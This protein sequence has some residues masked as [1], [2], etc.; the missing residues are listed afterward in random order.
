M[1]MITEGDFM[2]RTSFPEIYT[3]FVDSEDKL[4][5]KKH[6][7]FS[8]GLVYGVL[9]QG[10][11]MESRPDMVDI[12]RLNQIKEEVTKSIIDF[13]FMLLHD[14]KDSEYK[15]FNKMLNIADEGVL[16]LKTIYDEHKYLPLHD[17]IQ[18]SE[19]LWKERYN[20]Y[21]ILNSVSE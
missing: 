13:I 11:M 1:V 15:T 12:V 2:I 3:E 19:K 9:H 8:L 18:E 6:H 16:K 4:F 17:L 14:N 21:P 5:Q 20:N 7:L 10:E